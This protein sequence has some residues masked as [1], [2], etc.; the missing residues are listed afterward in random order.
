[1]MPKFLY[2]KFS[3]KWESY[4]ITLSY[5][6]ILMYFCT[7]VFTFIGLTFILSA[8]KNDRQ[9][10]KTGDNGRINKDQTDGLIKVQF[11]K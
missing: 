2:F 10:E 8:E 1:M 5:K 4:L 11:K 9:Q 6:L 7:N 3:I